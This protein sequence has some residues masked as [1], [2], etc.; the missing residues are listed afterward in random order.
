MNQSP[1]ALIVMAKR[2]FPGQTKTR[3]TPPLS[4]TAAADLYACF[5]RDEIALARSLPGVTSFI[6]YAPHDAEAY[7]R[8]LAPGVQLIPQLG[9]TLGER[10]NYV[11][12]HCLDAGFSQVAAMNSDS[13]T[14]PQRY[15]AQAFDELNDVGTDVVLGP[16]DDGGYYLIGWKRPYPRLVCGV[17]MSTSHV[18]QDTMAIAAVEALRVTLLPAWY[19]VDDEADL[20][21]VFSD[22]QAVPNDSFT[23]D[24]LK[25]LY[26]VQES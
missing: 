16:C 25:E 23:H 2:P 4:A 17:E 7:F 11:L 9:E 20:Q 6:A 26:G 13:P 15:L 10:L 5:L 22:L 21:R 1:S 18:L 14:L 3:L 19:D 24:F 12:T 8:A